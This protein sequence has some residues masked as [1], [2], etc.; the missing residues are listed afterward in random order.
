MG[1]VGGGR[2][3]SRGLQSSPLLEKIPWSCTFLPQ[4][5]PTS[6]PSCCRGLSGR[7]KWGGVGAAGRKGRKE[8]AAVGRAP[9]GRP[10]TGP[11]VLRWPASQTGLNVQGLLRV[12]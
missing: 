11:I 8:V 3:G 4:A 12:A 5:I 10:T 6:A 1:A 2:G 9:L 7:W